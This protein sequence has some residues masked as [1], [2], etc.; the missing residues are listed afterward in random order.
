MPDFFALFSNF[1]ALPLWQGTSKVLND[2]IELMHELYEESITKTY[3][4]V[5]NMMAILGVQ[6]FRSKIG[7]DNTEIPTGA[8]DN[9][10]ND[11][12]SLEIISNQTKMPEPKF[13]VLQV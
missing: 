1:R 6:K 7:N 2:D 12:E 11:I 4:M 13:G 5:P 8:N 10:R 3:K 9:I